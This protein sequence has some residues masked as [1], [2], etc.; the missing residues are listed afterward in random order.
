M[1][2]RKKKN[3]ARSEQKNPET[4]RGN[5]LG[6]VTE[7]KAVVGEGSKRKSGI[8]CCG[9]KRVNGQWDKRGKNLMGCDH[10]PPRR[11]RT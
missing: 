6:F 11:K 3:K 1:V 2:K 4:K 9:G 10:R 5:F 7:K 8:R